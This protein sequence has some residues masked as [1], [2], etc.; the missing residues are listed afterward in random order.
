M[1][2]ASKAGHLLWD[3]QAYSM[4]LRK[5]PRA[6]LYFEFYSRVQCL[7]RAPAAKAKV[8]LKTFSFSV[9]DSIIHF[10]VYLRLD[11]IAV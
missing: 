10:I 4:L 5:T 8:K 3:S 2:E 7:E 11:T 6:R 9:Q 1:R